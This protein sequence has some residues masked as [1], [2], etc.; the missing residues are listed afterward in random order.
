MEALHK[1]YA[2]KRE[3]LRMAYQGREQARRLRA[4]ERKANPPKPED[5]TIRFWR[6]DS[7]TADQ[8]AT[9]KEETR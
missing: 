9:Q 6:V 2:H 7:Q 8:T 5:I 3:T 4:A 1:L